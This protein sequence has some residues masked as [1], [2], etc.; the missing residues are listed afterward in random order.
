MF[1]DR[2]EIQVQFPCN[3]TGESGTQ[4]RAYRF[5]L[6]LDSSVTIRQS[7]EDEK[8]LS[9]I[10]CLKTPPPYSKQLAE[11]NA[12]HF[13]AASVKWQEEDRWLRQTDLTLTKTDMMQARNAPV[14]IAVSNLSY[15]NLGRW[16]QYRLTFGKNEDTLAALQVFRHACLD[17]NVP[18]GQNSR[19]TDANHRLSMWEELKLWK[20]Q[21]SG[22][23]TLEREMF[24]TDLAFEVLYQLEVCVSRGLLGEY[25]ID[26]AFFSKLAAI[27]EGK[28]VR[29]LENVVSDGKSYPCA[30]D[31]FQ[32]Y[33]LQKPRKPLKVPSN[34]TLMHSVTVTATTIRVQPVT[35]EL[36]NRIIRQY[37]NYADRFLRVRFEDDD[38]R[39]NSRIYA[40][41]SAKMSEPFVRVKRA[42]LK[43]IDI[44]GRHYEFL[45]WGNSQLRDHGAF[46]FAPK[47]EI[48][49]GG[50]K[51]MTDA[52]MIV[53]VA[54][55]FDDET[56]IAKRAARIG[57]CFSTTR[58]I[59]GRI[60][61]VT[62]H[63]CIPD[64]E[65]NGHM[66]SDGCGKISQLLAAQVSMQL[67]LRGDPPSAYQFR[68]GGC[69]GILVVA[70]DL[71]N[72]EVKIRQSQY[73]FPSDA[74]ALEIITLL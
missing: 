30:K 38:Y 2:N 52:A 20:Q 6:S 27:D 58:N 46:F 34:C 12:M 54:G 50:K 31:V 56:I 55:D 32:Q 23:T 41:T 19:I 35:V 57:Q 9:L 48:L 44:A 14:A 26:K 25:S 51:T 36:S 11:S 70:P 29:L 13:D 18:I 7:H 10:F 49:D 63:D 60:D 74:T 37:R 17:S 28:A 39:G 72:R 65:R 5:L 33:E 64:I 40:T 22:M 68:L 62:R 53:K 67:K 15:V 3:F 71:K 16:T 4:I 45:A 59:I 8:S 21:F 47:E 73:K 43:G 61:R 42:L 66:F 1:V 24:S 69:K